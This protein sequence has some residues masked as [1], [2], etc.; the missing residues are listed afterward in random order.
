MQQIQDQPKKKV[1]S[2]IPKQR[3]II[4][5]TAALLIGVLVFRLMTPKRSVAAYCKT[6]KAENAKLP[7]PSNSER[8][9]STG[10]LES[11]SSN[12]AKFAKA[13]GSLEKVAPEEIHHDVKALKMSFEKID[14]DPTQELSV[15]LSAMGPDSNVEDWTKKNCHL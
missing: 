1:P 9:W 12:P 7:K 14:K 2:I 10:G 15:S 5:I 8:T 3:I 13:F 6:F 11:N 4:I